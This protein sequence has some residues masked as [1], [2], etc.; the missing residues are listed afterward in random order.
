MI[1]DVDFFVR[2]MVA[3][4]LVFIGYSMTCTAA[5]FIKAGTWLIDMDVPD[6]F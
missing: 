5:L 6:E 1:R 2:R 4:P 3:W